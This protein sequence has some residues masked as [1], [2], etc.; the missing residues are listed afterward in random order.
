[1]NRKTID[2]LADHAKPNESVPHRPGIL[3]YR[4]F[5]VEVLPEPVKSYVT[6]CATSLVCDPAY[7]AV[8]LIPALGSLI[9]NA[10]VIQL[11]PGWTE[12]S[13]FWTAILGESGTLKTPAFKRAMKAVR[14]LQRDEMRVYAEKKSKF[15]N[16]ELHYEK[17]LREWKN[18]GDGEPPEKPNEPQPARF[19]VSD[20]T[21]E[22]L[23]PILK[24]NWRGVL[25]A[26]DELGGWILSFDRY[27]QARGADATH[28]LS[29]F[30]AE[31]VINDRKTGPERTIHI[32]RAA[33]S[34]VGGI[35]PGTFRRAVGIHHRENGLLARF[36]I[37]W[38][39]RQ[40]KK[41]TDAGILPEQEARIGSLCDR[42]R[43]LQ[44]QQFEDEIEPVTIRLT[45]EAKQ[46]WVQF[47]NAH[48]LEQTE[49][50]GDLCAA[51]SKLEAYSARLALLVHY[52]RWAAD[53]PT[54]VSGD[55]VDEQS[56][57]AG[58]TL[59]QW[60]GHEAR[61]VYAMLDESEDEQIRRRHV[62]LIENAGGSVTVRDWHQKRSHKFSRD[63]EAELV[64]LQNHGYGQLEFAKKPGPGRPSKRF[65]LYSASYDNKTPTPDPESG[66]SLVSESCD[67]RL[68]LADVL[69]RLRRDG[70]HDLAIDA[71]NEWRERLAI[72]TIDG[73][74][75]EVQGQAVAFESVL[76]MLNGSTPA[77]NGGAS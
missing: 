52:I 46:R 40:P 1:M 47:Y 23:L 43:E 61:R 49:M 12:P 75:T 29:M 17:A 3:P 73:G 38:P 42:L 16:E 55:V 56:L 20:T 74:L 13:I 21:V 45:P 2:Q 70:Q 15:E 68:G 64:D 53:D 72:T 63:A 18:K 39:P 9:G 22:A 4:P 65:T 26:R 28:W 66:V 7:V 59:S 36:L 19:I 14:D 76:T 31:T 77:I 30:N 27:A 25:L 51:W 71:R 37:A 11:K 10:R 24:E 44:P 6:T 35:Q 50:T 32:E 34:I 60:F 8:P 58:I 33:V 54:L 5:P 69:R 57:S 62:E 67:V 48:A 41:W